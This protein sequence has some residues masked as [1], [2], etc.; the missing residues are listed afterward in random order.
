MLRCSVLVHVDHLAVRYPNYL[1]TPSLQKGYF[2]MPFRHMELVHSKLTSNEGIPPILWSLRISREI[3]ENKLEDDSLVTLGISIYLS[4][5]IYLTLFSAT[6]SG[7]QLP[8]Y[9]VRFIPS[10]T[11]P[12]SRAS[13]TQTPEPQDMGDSDVDWP[14]RGINQARGYIATFQN[15][16]FWF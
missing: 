2:F 3:R 4:I 16:L 12:W 11:F 13:E 5:P 6:L 7:L 15:L 9:I 14:S 1:G 10:H 8:R